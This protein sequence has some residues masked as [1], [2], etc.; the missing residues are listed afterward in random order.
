MLLSLCTEHH[1][2]VSKSQHYSHVRIVMYAQAMAGYD[3]NNLEVSNDFFKTKD[4]IHSL[5]LCAMEIF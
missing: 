1:R 4:G 3:Q 5:A 2:R